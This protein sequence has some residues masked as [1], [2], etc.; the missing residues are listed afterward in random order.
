MKNIRVF[1]L[2]LG[3]GM[4]LSSCRQ[5]SVSGA[6]G[7][8]VGTGGGGPGGGTVGSGAEASTPS[9]EVAA[10]KTGSEKAKDKGA[11]DQQKQIQDQMN[12]TVQ[13][14]LRQN[15]MILQQLQAERANQQALQ[16]MLQTQRQT[17]QALESARQAAAAA[18]QERKR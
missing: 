6:K 4:A 9:K 5:E 16:N 3:T 17:Q 1:L 11:V 15:Q 13:D 18:Q 8:T 2:V 7:G 10:A 14:T 12:K